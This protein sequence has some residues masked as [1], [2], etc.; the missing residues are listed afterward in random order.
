VP[1]NRREKHQRTGNQVNVVRSATHQISVFTAESND[2]PFLWA[3]CSTA[4]A[5]CARSSTGG[6][7]AGSSEW[8]ITTFASGAMLRCVVAGA[9][10]EALQHAQMNQGR[11]GVLCADGLHIARQPAVQD[12]GACARIKKL[13]VHIRVFAV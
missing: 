7:S 5:A 1:E 6:S 4:S 8:V 13:V 2:S 11:H 10:R 9:V 12:A 3:A